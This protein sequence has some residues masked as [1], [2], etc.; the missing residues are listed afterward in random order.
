MA[1]R[2]TEPGRGGAHAEPCHQAQ[3]VARGGWKMPGA[4][5]VG[6]GEEGS[7]IPAGAS[8]GAAAGVAASQPHSVGT[9]GGPV[10]ADSGCG[11]VGPREQFGP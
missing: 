6:R 2:A 8:G 7:A 9:G 10:G 5:W 3:A 11:T 1:A 4:R